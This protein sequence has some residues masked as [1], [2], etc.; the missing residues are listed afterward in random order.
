[1]LTGFT[2]TFSSLVK[3]ATFSNLHSHTGTRL[4][5]VSSKHFLMSFLLTIWYLK[6]FQGNHQKCACLS[7]SLPTFKLFLCY[8]LIV[9][10]A[11]YTYTSKTILIHDWERN[12]WTMSVART[13]HYKSILLLLQKQSLLLRLIDNIHWECP[14]VVDMVLLQIKKTKK[15]TLLVDLF[16]IW[17]L[18]WLIAYV[19]FFLI[20]VKTPLLKPVVWW[21]HVPI[22]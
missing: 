5:H 11:E 22:S 8:L 4:V 2:E 10:K 20:F 21:D 6:H 9:W 14:Q 7:C 12:A 19:H 15:K 3:R 16:N 13:L 17:K 18:N 1:M